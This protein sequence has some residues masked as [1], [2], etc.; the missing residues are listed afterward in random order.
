[1]SLDIGPIVE[2][3]EY[4][5]E[6]LNVRL[7]DG[8]DGKPKIQIRI[9][10]GLLQ[11]EATGRPDGT[12]PYG[13]ESLLD[14]YLS[15]LD[16]YRARHGHTEGFGLDHRD[17]ELLFQ[18]SMQYYY[19][20]ISFLTLG[21]YLK[22][23]ADA[24]HNLRIMDLRRDYASSEEDRTA[25]EEYRGFVLMQRT[26]A[27]GKFHL[28]KKDYEGALSAIDRGI[29]QIEG[30]FRRIG[31]EDLIEEGRELFLLREWRKEV[32]KEKPLGPLDKLRK[33]LQAAIEREDYERAAILRDQ[34]KAYEKLS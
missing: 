5:P 34:I 12:R 15:L 31:R 9:D 11:L 19:R 6:E 14:H 18:E 8:I 27:E 10:M 25:S 1:M 20:R 13:K 17:C 22:A 16:E 2:S 29:G 26:Q 30:F 3:W 23:I 4:K 21:M 28:E 32:A 7:I 33:E 24:D